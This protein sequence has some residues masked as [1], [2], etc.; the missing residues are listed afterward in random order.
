VDRQAKGTDVGL[1]WRPRSVVGRVVQLLAGGEDALSGLVVDAQ[2]LA[3]LSTRDAT[4]AVT[5][6]RA[7]RS[8]R[9]GMATP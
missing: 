2:G 8:A 9:R 7:A 4:D 1:T 3:L 5:P 6:G